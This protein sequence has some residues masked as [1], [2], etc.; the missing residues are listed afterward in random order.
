MKL[1]TILFAALLGLASSA[2]FAATP[3]PAASNNADQG[4]KHQ[5]PCEKNPAECKA[6]A[7]KFDQ[8]CSA[9]ADKCIKLKSWAER[10]IERCEADK[11]KCKEMHEKM[12][13]RHEERRD[14]KQDQEQGDQDRDQD[15]DQQPP[16]PPLFF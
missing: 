10:R 4:E 1:T 7:A 3:S 15:N 6:D 2:A 14:D 8:W 16:P 11:E 12:R 9:N 13:E 5:G